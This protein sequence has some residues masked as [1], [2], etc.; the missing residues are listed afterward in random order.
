MSIGS[1][2]KSARQIVA[3]LKAS[4]KIALG[5]AIGTM[6]IAWTAAGNEF[7]NGRLEIGVVL[8]GA[9]ILPVYRVSMMLQSAFHRHVIG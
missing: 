5:L 3:R 7:A 9:P 8:M 6:A 2:W 1:V 4:E